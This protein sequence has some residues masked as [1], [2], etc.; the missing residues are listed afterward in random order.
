MQIAGECFLESRKDAY[1]SCVRSLEKSRSCR[2][3]ENENANIDTRVKGAR[4]SRA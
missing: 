2:E 1:A 3:L 4:S